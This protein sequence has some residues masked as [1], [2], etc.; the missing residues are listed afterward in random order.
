MTFVSKRIANSGVTK[1]DSVPRYPS[2]T[3]LTLNVNL[4]LK[5]MLSDDLLEK[6]I[7]IDRHLVSN[8]LKIIFRC[9]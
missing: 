7:A 6:I 5:L 3:H 9:F 4:T 8:S 2:K 1:H